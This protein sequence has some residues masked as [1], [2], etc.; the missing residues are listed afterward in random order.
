MK[1]LYV[2]YIG[3]NLEDLIQANV[4]IVKDLAG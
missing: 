3:K 2:I 4:P 1:N